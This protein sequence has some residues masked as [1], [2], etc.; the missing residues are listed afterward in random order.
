[1]ETCSQPSNPEVL[2]ALHR[3]TEATDLFPIVI[4]PLCARLN[5]RGEVSVEQFIK[6]QFY[7]LREGSSS[8]SVREAE[9]SLAMVQLYLN[10][11]QD[12]MA[13]LEP[14]PGTLEKVFKRWACKNCILLADYC[15]EPDQRDP[16]LLGDLLVRLSDAESFLSG[17]SHPQLKQVKLESRKRKRQAIS[18]PPS[19]SSKLRSGSFKEEELE[20]NDVKKEEKNY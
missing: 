4:R 7:D 16:E 11:L 9:R 10:R 1:M 6:A 13:A 15:A 2:R 8:E 14:V 5:L 19:M 12:L 17:A 3:I 20:W 18:P